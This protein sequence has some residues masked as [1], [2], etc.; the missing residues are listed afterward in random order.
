[1]KISPLIILLIILFNACSWISESEQHQLREIKY[2]FNDTIIIFHILQDMEK[3]SKDKNKIE[4]EYFW[5][6]NNELKHSYGSY[7]GSV[8]HGPFVSY[9]PDGNLKEKGEFK[10][11]KKHRLWRK[12]HN[13]GKIKSVT[14]WRNGFKHGSEKNYNNDGMLMCED[15]FKK[16]KKME[17]K[18]KIKKSQT[19]IKDTTNILNK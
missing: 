4:I 11:G 13:N 7:S 3:I 1:M 18:K 14:Q 9:Y 15:I 19:E 10:F 2:N 17:L 8:A 12:W 16:G 5:A 6:N